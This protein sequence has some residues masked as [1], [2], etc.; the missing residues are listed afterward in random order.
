MACGRRLFSAWTPKIYYR[1][2]G[3]RDPRRWPECRQKRFLERQVGT[4]TH[5]DSTFNGTGAVPR[6]P[7]SITE[8]RARS[9]LLY[10]RS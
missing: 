10:C 3:Y 2:R 6:R 1:N 8:R 9:R 5:E 7:F 4:M